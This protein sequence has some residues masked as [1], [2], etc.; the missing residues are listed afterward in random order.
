MASDLVYDAIRAHI[1][2]NWTL[3]P[4]DR[5]FWEN[6]PQPPDGPSMIVVE[7]QGTLY[8]QVGFGHD[9]QAE[10]R[11]DETG[12]LLVHCMV[13]E[14]TGAQFSRQIARTMANLFR[15]TR[16]MSQSLE[17]QDAVIGM[18]GGLDGAEGNWWGVT[19]SI[20]W[21]RMED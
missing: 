16:L 7:L 4:L 6:E 11:W 2:G 8:A 12:V 10:N 3:T 9:E 20:D 13:P 5:F 17:F 14:G 18:G 15:G 1:E 21:R 19:V